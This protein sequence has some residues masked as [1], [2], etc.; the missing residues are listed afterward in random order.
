M[1][2]HSDEEK[3]HISLQSLKV[4][5]AFF[6]DIIESL[7][8]FIPSAYVAIKALHLLTRQT[9]CGCTFWKASLAPSTRNVPA[10]PSSGVMENS[11]PA[12]SN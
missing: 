4:S 11:G 2:K 1:F 8:C 10:C 5:P 7:L 6:G 12:D 9:G 3:P